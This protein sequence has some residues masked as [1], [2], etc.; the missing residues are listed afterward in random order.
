[1]TFSAQHFPGILLKNSSAEPLLH[2]WL[3]FIVVS[4]KHC[5][6][7]KVNFLLRV[8]HL[9]Y[10]FP[11][12][13]YK[14]KEFFVYFIIE[15]ELRKCHQ[16]R[17]LVTFVPS[18]NCSEKFPSWVAS[19]KHSRLSVCMQLVHLSMTLWQSHAFKYVTIFLYYFLCITLA[20]CLVAGRTC[21][22]IKHLALCFSSLSNKPQKGPLNIACLFRRIL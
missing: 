11:L 8:H 19:F 20:I 22:P 6:I 12:V 17:Y 18:S 14:N 3:H 10:M 9:C 1:M 4:T 21:T 5:F 16:L 2:Q 13:V 15:T 7:K